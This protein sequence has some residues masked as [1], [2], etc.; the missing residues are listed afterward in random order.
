MTIVKIFKKARK[1]VFVPPFTIIFNMKIIVNVLFLLFFWFTDVAAQEV[2]SVIYQGQNKLSRAASDAI[3]ASGYI[4]VTSI[5]SYTLQLGRTKSKFTLDSIKYERVEEEYYSKYL[6]WETTYKN[7]NDKSF[8][9]A[10]CAFDDGQCYHGTI[11][12]VR[13]VAIDRK[14]IRKI[15]GFTCYSAVYR[16]GDVSYEAWFTEDLPFSDGPFG[17]DS[18]KRLTMPLLPG[19]ILEVMDKSTGSYLHAKNIVV[20]T[21]PALNNTPSCSV[22]Q[23]V[24]NFD[25]MRHFAAKQ[26]RSIRLRAKDIILGKWYHA[27]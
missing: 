26:E 14:I 3:I 22:S 11:N 9:Y 23:D 25:K 17:L 16:I 21:Q 1:G 13:D 19:V 4:P 18:Q 15:L 10:E 6:C 20:L 2:V 24:E 27:H 12:Y 5:D 8:N 7:Y